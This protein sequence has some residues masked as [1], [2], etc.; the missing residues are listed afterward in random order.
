[1]VYSTHKYPLEGSPR[2]S[3]TSPS[4]WGGFSLFTPSESSH[5][6]HTPASN[7][8]MSPTWM[9][10]LPLMP[11]RENRSLA[12]P[13]VPPSSGQVPPLLAQSVTNSTRP[14][15]SG[16]SSGSRKTYFPTA[17]SGP[18]SPTLASSSTAPGCVPP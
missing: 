13:T 4:A 3:S 5:F 6:T 7:S 16:A 18:A 8:N 2:S 17:D 9:V 12:T 14:A 1:R 15:A 11:G 10:S